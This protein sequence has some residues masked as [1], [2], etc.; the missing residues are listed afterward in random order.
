MSTQAPLVSLMETSLVS[1][2]E[3]SFE[4]PRLPATTSVIMTALKPIDINL[5]HQKFLYMNSPN[6]AQDNAWAESLL[7]KEP[8]AWAG[9]SFV[10]TAGFSLPA[11]LEAGSATRAAANGPASTVTVGDQLD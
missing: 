3:P 10:H 2:L 5:H 6:I 4:Q 1:L 9:G 7:K 8:P 11:D